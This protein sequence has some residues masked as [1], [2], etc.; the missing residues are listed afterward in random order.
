MNSLSPLTTA[1]TDNNRQTLLLNQCPKNTCAHIVELLPQPALGTQD[2]RVTL[3]LKELGFLPGAAVKVIGFGLLG[4]DPIAVQ[5]NG[6]KFA[7]RHAEAA[8]IVIQIV[9]VAE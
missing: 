1:A 7:L 9:D 5:V 3:R 6:T 4:H 8:K 2:E